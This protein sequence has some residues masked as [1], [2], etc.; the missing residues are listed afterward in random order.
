LYRLLG[1]A[2]DV[3]PRYTT[4][5]P[6]LHARVLEDGSDDLV[7]VQHRGWAAAVDDATSV[8]RDAELIYDRGNSGGSFGEKGVR[9]YRVRGV[10]GA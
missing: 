3:Q 8:P 7:I 6:D 9:I 5:H 1:E 2:A 10:R 4:L